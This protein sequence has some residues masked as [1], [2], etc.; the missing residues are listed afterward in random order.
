MRFYKRSKTDS[1]KPQDTAFAVEADGRII[2]TTKVGIEVPAGGYADRYSTPDNG[3]IRYNDEI[4]ELEAY[5][6]G[7]WEIIK[8][9]RQG[10]V[11]V[12]TFINGDY[13]DRYFGPL[14]Y[15]VD[16]T[17]PQNISVYVDNVFQVPFTNYTLERSDPGF[18]ITTSTTV[19]IAAN[20]GD[21]TIFL[22]S[23]ADF[24]P[25]RILS[26]TNLE[27]CVIVSTSSTTQTIEI[28]PGAL[29]FIPAGGLATVNISTGTYI[30][31]EPDAV[32]TP[33]KPV[34]AILGL[35]GYNPPFL[36]E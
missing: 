33:S 5:I 2:T 35:D 20:F 30:A 1:I 17:K 4:D 18:P 31:F 27:G 23:I 3:T 26:G 6:N 7:N 13:A 21:T 12:D 15:N 32:P 22:D 8:T 25:G 34:T 28:S 19:S 16:I 9:N 29:G 36:E 14:S 24:N 10:T 11:T